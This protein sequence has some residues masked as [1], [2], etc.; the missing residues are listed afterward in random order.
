MNYSCPPMTQ[1]VLDKLLS[2]AGFSNHD[3]VA[4][5][6]AQLSHKNVQ[7]ARTGTRPVTRNVARTIVDAANALLQPEA[8]LKLP[9]IFPGASFLKPER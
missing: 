1:T 6:S 3:L 8:P 9:D 5:S 7:K 2:D 4:A